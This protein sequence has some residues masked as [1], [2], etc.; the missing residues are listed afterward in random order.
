[1][2]FVGAGTIE[3]EITD[4]LTLKDKRQVVR[5][6]LDRVRARFNVAAAEVDHLDS[7]R[8]ATLALAAVA[9]DQ[10]HVHQVLE[11]AVDLVESEPRAAVLDY[12]IQML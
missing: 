5:A 3:L 7:P 8:F 11:K 9:N 2:W 4:S 10:A 12:E 1:M 6:L